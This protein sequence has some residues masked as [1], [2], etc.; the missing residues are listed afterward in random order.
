M[1]KLRSVRRSKSARA[2][3]AIYCRKLAPHRVGV[4]QVYLG[5][6][7]T[8]AIYRLALSFSGF[9]YAGFWQSRCHFLILPEGAWRRK[10]EIQRLPQSKFAI[11]SSNT[12]ENAGMWR[13]LRKR[14]M[15]EQKKKKDRGG[16]IGGTVR[17]LGIVA[18]TM[19]IVALLWKGFSIGFGPTA[20]LALDFYEQFMHAL[21]GWAEPPLHKMLARLGE[22]TG[23]HLSLSPHWKHVLV[24]LTLYVSACVK[25]TW[26]EYQGSKLVAVLVATIGAAIS[27]PASV[28]AGTVPLD[29]SDSG[30]WIAAYPIAAICMFEFA[31]TAIDA[32][33][34]R[35]AGPRF[36][37]I[38]VAL[39]L[40]G[41]YASEIPVLREI[42]N[43][44]LAVLATFVVILGLYWI[45]YGANDPESV[46]DTRWQRFM[47]AAATRLG[48]ILF[49]SVA[50]A[51]VFI[52]LNAGLKELGL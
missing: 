41:A 50:G 38:G 47:S 3:L 46:G 10:G 45:I 35:N 15:A 8:F 26:S 39:L 25:S 2:H 11:I 34:F 43:I 29:S 13:P 37:I 27:I 36:A 32:A 17:V 9:F 16:Y 23:L 21:F 33:Y 49:S 22:L 42:P 31:L 7:V 52:L 18:G 4:P 28:A 24:L 30:L 14:P 5:G 51:V 19:S 20:L 48:L 44:G 1:R 6:G 40:V 12:F